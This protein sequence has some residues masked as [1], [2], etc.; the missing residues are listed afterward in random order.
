M[1]LIFPGNIELNPGLFNRHQI[2]KENFKVFNNEGFHFMHLSINSLLNN[3]PQ[4]MKYS[5][6]DFFSK[7]NQI[8][9][10]IR[11]WSHLLKK[12]LMENLIDLNNDVYIIGDFNMNFF[13]RHKYV[14]LK[15]SINICCQK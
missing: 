15:I 9:W 1:T 2:K 8:N 4:K 12:S 13:F 7:C 3:I 11:I 10:K 6:K 5:T 14:L